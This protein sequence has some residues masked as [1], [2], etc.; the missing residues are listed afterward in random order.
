MKQKFTTSRAA[1]R[2]PSI[3]SSY[4]YGVPVFWRR[5][6]GLLGADHKEFSAKHPLLDGAV[7]GMKARLAAAEAAANPCGP[8]R[9]ERR[10]NNRRKTA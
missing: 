4:P 3:T 8:S 1:N 5:V 2:G 7:D 6:Q 9:R 10:E